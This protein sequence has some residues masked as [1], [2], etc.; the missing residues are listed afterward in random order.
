MREIQDAAFLPRFKPPTIRPYDGE[1]NPLQFLD[2]YSTAIRA[3]GGGP[4]EMC[5]LFPLA[6][7]GMAQTCFYNLQKNSVH[8]WE[9]LQEVFIAIF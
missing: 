2:V 1:S 4:T 8:S 9:R 6:L 5:S 7:T 3:A